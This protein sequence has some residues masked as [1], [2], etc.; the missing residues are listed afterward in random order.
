M[1]GIRSLDKYFNKGKQNEIH[2]IN[3]ISLELPERGMVAIFGQS[4]CGKTTLLNVLGGLDRFSGGSVEIDGFDIRSNTDALRNNYIGYIFQNYN[5]NKLESNFDNVADALR[6]CGMKDEAEI[7]TRVLAALRNVNMEKYR[8]RTPD[9]LSGGQQQRIAIARAIVKNPRIILADEPT[10]NLDEANTILIMDLLKEISRDHLVVLVTHEANLVDYYC[11]RVIELSDGKVVNVRDNRDANGYSAKN[12]NDIF[13]GELEKTELNGANTSIEYYGDAPSSPI[14]LRIVNDGGKL[15]LSVEDQKIQ[16]LD[17]S[18]EVR[19]REGKF[20]SRVGTAEKHEKIDMSALPPVE[21]TEFGKLFNFKNSIKSGY[22]A[23][24]KGTRKKTTKALRAVMALFSAVLVFMAAVCGISAKQLIK[25]NSGYNHNVFYVYVDSKELADRLHDSVGREGSGIDY[26]RLGD[27]YTTEDD[28]VRFKA[29]YFE[30]FNT[31]SYDLNFVT[32]AVVLG[33]S[34]VEGKTP[35][36]GKTTGLSEEEI[37]ITTAS[38][39]VMLENSPLGYISGY[40]DMIGMLSTSKSVGGKSLRI[41]GIIKSDETAIYLSDVSLAEDILNN[42]M[43]MTVFPSEDVAP[44]SAVLCGG[45]LD[46]YGTL[47]Q[48]GSTIKI[49]GKDFVLTKISTIARSYPEWLLV[50][51]VKKLDLGEWVEEQIRAENPALVRG[52]TEFDAKYSEISERRYFDYLTYYYDGL[53]D[54]CR[55][56]YSYEPY[57]MFVWL[58]VK[59]GSENAKLWFTEKMYYYGIRCKNKIG[60][61]PTRTEIEEYSAGA[62]DEFGYLEKSLWNEFEELGGYDVMYG[63]RDETLRDGYRINP[64]DFLEISKLVGE[65]DRFATMNSYYEIDYTDEKGETGKLDTN[66]IRNAC[67]AVVHSADVSA[68]EEYLYREFGATETVYDYMLPVIT[69]DNQFR[70]IVAEYIVDIL[71]DAVS[72]LAVIALMSVCMY[73]IMRST[74]LSRIKEIGI[75][76][77]IGVSKKNLIFRFIVESLVLTTVTVFVGYLISSVAIFGMIRMSPIMESVFYYPWWSAGILLVLIYAICIFCGTIPVRS[78]LRKTPAEILAKYD[79]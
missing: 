19:L 58:A 68:T 12:K 34:L 1:I 14:R 77:A 49:R 76:R 17:E 11:D 66:R 61:T 15:Y 4:G 44:G 51:S 2:V 70:T 47:P 75:Y 3:D 59:G 35:V 33:R 8:K 31:S 20:E 13:L 62:D 9:T 48:V 18:S 5:L 28:L 56:Y 54:F 72:I 29:G 7:E 69:P 67:Y 50:N 43:G 71:T 63:A 46:G 41:A 27:L 6:L 40:R 26:I 23:N 24:F 36:C 42:Q 57:D 16:I 32:N 53:D 74:L 37:I 52:S 73:F 25:I 79:I 45:Y 22:A 78:L 21:G 64:A 38:A 55:D 65:S 60:R 30:T 39:D 10:G